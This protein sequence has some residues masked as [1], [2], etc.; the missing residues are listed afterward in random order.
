MD[1]ARLVRVEALALRDREFV[2]AARGLGLTSI[3]LVFGHVLPNLMPVV[4]VAGALRI[5]Q[6]ILV[7]SFLSFLGLGVPR[8]RWSP[9]GR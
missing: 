2:A 3:Q 5:G 8:S 6:I 4:L 7:E 1:V 9:G